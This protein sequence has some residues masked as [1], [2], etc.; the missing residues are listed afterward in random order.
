MIKMVIG[1]IIGIGLATTFPEQTADLSSF[2]KEQINAG[3][4]AIAD[5]TDDSTL[6]KLKECASK[7]IADCK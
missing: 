7:G 4:Q 3:A 6:A 2:L 1:G 5:N